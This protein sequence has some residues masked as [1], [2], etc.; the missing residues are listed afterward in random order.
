MTRS[1]QYAGTLDPVEEIRKQWILERPKYAA[2]CEELRMLAE[3]TCRNN[4]FHV[5]ITW[6]VKDIDSLVRKCIK[7]IRE[8]RSPTLASIVDKVGVRVVLRFLPE[9][10]SVVEEF[11]S[12][13][14]CSKVEFKSEAQKVNEFGY[15]SCH[16][17]VLLPTNHQ[18]HSTFLGFV[19][20]LQVRTLAQ[21]LW[22][23][24]AHELSY[25]SIFRTPSSPFQELIDRRIYILSAL[26]ESADMEFSRIN[27][28]MAAAPG[29]GELAI[30]RLLEREYFKYSSRPYDVELSV[31]AI[32]MFRMIDDRS[33]NGLSADLTDFAAEHQDR[34]VH[35][36]EDQSTNDD[37]SVFIFQPEALM[38]FEAFERKPM[39]LEEVWETYFPKKELERLATAW[40]VSVY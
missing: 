22:A 30:L 26:V 10:K 29:A 36:F 12:A 20:E 2:F 21:D 35:I 34:I 38:I 39:A 6:R 23:E 4:G 18:K 14:N 8:G 19:G 37:R 9:V 1:V 7:Q 25:K 17:D 33:I 13:F 28:E 32:A 40:G 31:E 3:E 15:K 27:D 11:K 5:R 16:L 24:M